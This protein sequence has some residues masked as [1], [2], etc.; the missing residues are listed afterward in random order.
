MPKKNAPIITKRSLDTN[1]FYSDFSQEETYF[2]ALV[3]SPTATGIVRN[4]FIEDL[5]EGYH[6]FTAKDIPGQNS[7]TINDI[8]IKIFS[9]GNVEFA[10]EPLGIIVGP[11]EAEVLKLLDKVT[12]NFDIETLESALK[13]AIKQQHR[14]LIDVSEKSSEKG[15]HTKNAVDKILSEINELPPL[16]TVLDT[17]HIEKNQKHI[18]ASR[19]IKTGLF[20]ENTIEEAEKILFADNEDC[21]ISEETW[22][23][24]LTDL[25]WQETTG[26]FCYME[27][28][29]IN[30][31]APT[32]WPSLIIKVLSDCLDIPEEKIFINK[33]NTSG[34]YSKGLWRTT[35]IT[36]QVAIAAFLLKKPVKLILTQKE[37]DLYM[38]PGVK[39]DITYK[40]AIKK[41]GT[42]TGISVGIDVD[43]GA[44]NPFVQEIIDR[45]AIASCNY[46][47]FE[48]VHILAQAHTSKNPPS[49]ICIKSI[50]SQAFFA[51][52]NQLQKLSNQVH[53]LPEDIRRVNTNPK[54]HREIDI[55][56]N[57]V[58]ETLVNTIRMSDFNR[59]YASFHMDAIDRLQKSSNPFFAVPLR[60]IGI[61]SAY[62]VSEFYGSTNFS[63]DTK[64]EVTLLPKER[65]VIHAIRPSEV[66]QNIWRETA[67]E[68]LQI[69]KENVLIDSDF[70]IKDIPPSPEDSFSTIGTMNELI[71]KCCNDIQKRRFHQ[72]LPITSKK[73]ISGAAKKNWDKV[74]FRGT[75][76]ANMSFATCVV[77]VEL[78]TYTYSE[79]IKGIWLTV[80]C[81]EL[82]DEQAALR[83]LR[84]EIQ[85]ELSM[86]VEEKSIHCDK[87]S[88]EFIHS[89]NK[90]GQVGALVHNTLP[91]AFSSA[92]SLALATQLTKLPCT[93]AQIFNLIKERE[94]STQLSQ[95][96]QIPQ[97][98]H[99][100]DSM[101]LHGI[102]NLLLEHM[103][104][105][106]S[107]TEKKSGD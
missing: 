94:T 76:Y 39:T 80:D 17:N 42:V 104:A 7:F 38:I 59:K 8:D 101:E 44:F 71:K 73:G 25:S 78:D 64:I 62:N 97:I 96:P 63:Y 20:A 30:V 5:P 16:N 91:A 88:I 69:K 98:L 14:P 79:K 53:L 3:R 56:S 58:L 93:E 36:A 85:Q 95:L 57:A 6:L 68:I 87:I 13:N 28:G 60:G 19:E 18:V 24:K 107:A 84:L 43:V 70:Y 54:N 32:K 74:A 100:M 1:G 86:L 92:L 103:P 52:E 65:V 12:I 106:N 49:S 51:I 66:I 40:T 89:K 67:A 47:K 72:P 31:Y 2:A 21:F 27:N 77:E 102:D 10:G 37:Q 41:D 75:P 11:D 9:F 50:D 22:T 105:D 46:Y 33:T 23:E 48:N 29:N 45:I 15:L 34:I 99:Q 82:F 83:T 4:I 61:S 81:G 55:P 90:S 35:Q 26:A